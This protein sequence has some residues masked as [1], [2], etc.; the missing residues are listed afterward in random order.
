[1]DAIIGGDKS[2]DAV[3]VNTPFSVVPGA[4]LTIARSSKYN[5]SDHGMEWNNSSKNGFYCRFK[6]SP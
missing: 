1:M 4:D 2:R 5:Y 6:Y 3:V